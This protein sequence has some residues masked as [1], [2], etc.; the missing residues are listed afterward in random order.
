M[1]P[2]LLPTPPLNRHTEE[3]TLQIPPLKKYSLQTKPKPPNGNVTH[4]RLSGDGWVGVGEREDTARD[5]RKKV[6]FLQ[7]KHNWISPWRRRRRRR[8]R[9][10]QSP[11]RGL[12]SPTTLHHHRSSSCTNERSSRVC[13][14]LLF[15]RKHSLPSR[16]ASTASTTGTSRTR[17]NTVRTTAV[18]GVVHTATRRIGTTNR[19]EP[20]ASSHHIYE[21]RYICIHMYVHG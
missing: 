18:D 15:I 10:H 21:N 7:T 17:R 20:F 11:T 8:R 6:L 13:L 19:T 12:L 1:A 5:R 16:C 2:R 9:H 14:F 4:R 3:T